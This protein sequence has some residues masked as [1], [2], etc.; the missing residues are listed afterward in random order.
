MISREK[1]LRAAARIYGEAGFRGA[2]TRR[3]ADEAGVN[4]VTLFRLFGSKAALIAEALRAYADADAPSVDIRLPAEPG[5]AERELTTWCQK[6]LEHLRASRSVIRKAMGELEEHPE[7]GPCM[8]EGTT[9]AFREL[10]RYA[11]A[12]ARTRGGATQREAAAAAAMLMSAL[13]AD[14]MGR[15]MMPDVYP[16]PASSAAALYVRVF[17]RALG[18]EEESGR[19]QSGPGRAS[20][21]GRSGRGRGRARSGTEPLGTQRA[22]PRG[23]PPGGPRTK[24]S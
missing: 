12:L 15:E 16:Q 3:I 5:D 23:G 8:G 21:V 13:F 20:R 17:L 19:R 1:L 14:A 24:S 11:E 18:C 9:S 2:T 6:R 22:A 7:M 4:E 10:C